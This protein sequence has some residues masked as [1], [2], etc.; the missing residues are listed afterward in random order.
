MFRNR[1]I[2][3]HQNSLMIKIEKFVFNPFQENTFVIYDETKECLIIDPGCMDRHECSEMTVFISAKGLKP[4]R[5]L[6]THCHVDH[7]VGNNFVCENYE[8]KPELHKAG[9]P[10]LKESPR[11]GQI[12]GF[13]IPQ[14]VLPENFLEH[15]DIIQ[16]GHSELK[17]VYTP[18]HVDGHVCFINEKQH[19]VITGDVLFKDS[20]GRTDFPTGDFDKLM[21][22]IHSQLFTLDDDYK[23]YCGHGQETSIGYEKVNNPFIKF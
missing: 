4:V 2:C 15:G 20:I 9:L 8:L 1:Y 6:Y 18:G 23:V 3:Q 14:P 13:D 11:H 17:V 5:L 10:F 7:V 21:N 19:F 16:F 22:S 12:Y